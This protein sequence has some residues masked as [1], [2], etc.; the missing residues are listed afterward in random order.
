MTD[1]YTLKVVYADCEDRIWR[2][3]QISS[4][5]FISKLGYTILATFDTLAYH[6]FD[7]TYKGTTYKLPS[8]FEYI[9]KEECLFCVKLKDL[10]L[11]IGDTLQM[12]YDY[13]CEQIFDITVT[14]IQPMQKGC[15]NAYPKVTNG[16]GMG[17]I[18]D[19]P[20]DELLE[21]IKDI[22]KNG[23]STFYYKENY[24]KPWNYKEYNMDIDN[25]LLKAEIG[26]IDEGYSAFEAYL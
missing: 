11:K 19:M 26:L 16:Q 10:D 4:N 3:I 7:I 8:D 1:V 9:D 17:I 15:G 21:I 25:T 5:N 23:T 13:G 6:L 2:D 12:C 24:I 14:D 18:D 22:D 20:A